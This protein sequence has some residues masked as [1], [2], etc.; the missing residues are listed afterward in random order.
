MPGTRQEVERP[1]VDFTLATDVLAWVAQHVRTGGPFTSEGHAA[2]T[3]LARLRAEEAAVR[4][5]CEQERLPFEQDV[6]WSLYESAIEASVPTRRGRRPRGLAPGRQVKRVI[7]GVDAGLLKWV[8]GHCQPKGPFETAS[9]AVEAA[10]R[11]LMG[12]ESP[13]PR[14]PLDAFR[15]QASEWLRRYRRKLE[16]R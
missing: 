1:R 14:M 7:A 10:L 4:A 13:E 12:L 8:D 2:E 6:F 11:H 3:A 15:F 5:L 9:H 16:S